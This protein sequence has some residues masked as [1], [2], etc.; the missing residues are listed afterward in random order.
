MHPNKTDIAWLQVKPKDILWASANS[1][2][3]NCSFC[4]TEVHNPY[5]V[6]RGLCLRLS[7]EFVV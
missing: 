7:I 4:A 2:P 1:L 3:I 6:R 5:G